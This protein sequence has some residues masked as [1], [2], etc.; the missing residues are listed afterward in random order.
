MSRKIIS[1]IT[2]ITGDR[3]IIGADELDHALK[4]FILPEDIFLELLER[5]L[6][7]PNEVFVDDKNTRAFTTCFIG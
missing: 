2:A 4:H 5:V 6:K 3:V 7:D 1:I